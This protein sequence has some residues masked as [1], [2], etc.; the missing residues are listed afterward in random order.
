MDT[1]FRQLDHTADLAFE[2]TAATERS[3]LLG[4]ASNLVAI[5][6]S[7][8]ERGDISDLEE[9]EILIEALDGE[10]RLVRWLNEIIYL[11]MTGT[12]LFH[13]AQLELM[14]DAVMRAVCRGETDALEK[15]TS[16]LKCATYHDLVVEE[17]EGGW[18]ARVVIDV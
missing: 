13:S 18:Y 8:V 1:T 9:R 17:R 11:A 6:T 3:L 4:A 16:E 2:M 14:G 5:M 7:E 15:I 10:D 12:F